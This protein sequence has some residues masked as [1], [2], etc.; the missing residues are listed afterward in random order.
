[1]TF[2]RQLPPGGSRREFLALTRAQVS[3]LIAARGINGNRGAGVEGAQYLAL[4][5]VIGPFFLAS[6]TEH[7][8]ANYFRFHRGLRVHRSPRNV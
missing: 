5:Q 4:R 1:M 3:S 7:W 6:G 2:R 8:E